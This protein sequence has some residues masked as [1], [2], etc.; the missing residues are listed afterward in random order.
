MR[1]LASQKQSQ[2]P[3]KSPFST[4]SSIRSIGEELLVIIGMRIG[5][6]PGGSAFWVTGC[7]MDEPVSGKVRLPGQDLRNEF[8]PSM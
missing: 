3:C 7:W 8:T 1:G 5:S 2:A 4:H 6:S